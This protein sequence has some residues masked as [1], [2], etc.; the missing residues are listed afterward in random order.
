MDGDDIY[1]DVDSEGFVEDMRGY[2]VNQAL[3]LEV[4]LSSGHARMCK[5]FNC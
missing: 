3:P 2:G 5:T 1:S 4:C